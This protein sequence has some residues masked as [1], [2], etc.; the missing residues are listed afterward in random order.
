M[1]R[2]QARKKD[3][4]PA[5]PGSTEYRDGMLQGMPQSSRYRM[6]RPGVAPTL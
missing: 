4:S 3:V 1:L 2:S 6:V 5:S